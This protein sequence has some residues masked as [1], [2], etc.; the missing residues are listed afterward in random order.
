MN[1]RYRNAAIA[2]LVGLVIGSGVAATSYALWVDK[3]DFNGEL[4]GGYIHF[5]VDDPKTNP[6]SLKRISN[7]GEELAWSLPRGEAGRQLNG[8]GQPAHILRDVAPN[9]PQVAAI[10]ID[11]QSQGNRGMSWGLDDVTVDGDPLLTN[12]LHVRIAKVAD[13][14]ACVVGATAGP[15]PLY[16]GPLSTAMISQKPLVASTYKNTLWTTPQK[17]YLCMEFSVGENL[18]DYENTATVN[19][20]AES[21]ATPAPTVTD[22]D[23]WNGQIVPSGV[24]RD[25]KVDFNF[26]YTTY[27]PGGEPTP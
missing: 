12:L 13:A 4:T 2:A 27:R 14:A 23:S 15:N 8:S 17:T 16:S 26:S 24:S 5:A 20:T 19:G 11:E 25:A 7:F 21:L 1:S 18:G 6:A 9:A 22:S 10:E 3:T